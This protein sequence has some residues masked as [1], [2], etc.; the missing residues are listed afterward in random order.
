M[1]A[2]ISSIAFFRPFGALHG[3]DRFRR[4]NRREHQ[5]AR[6]DA[7]IGDHALADQI[8]GGDEVLAH[9]G[10]AAVARCAFGVVNVQ[11]YNRNACVHGFADRLVKGGVILDHDGDTIHLVGDG[12]LDQVVLR[13]RI[14]VAVLDVQIHAEHL[15]GVLGTLLDGHK[16][17]NGRVSVDDERNLERFILPGRLPLEQPAP[18]R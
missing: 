7:V 15:G 11:R 6:D 2:P 14:A 16:E 3:V 10:H 12:G 8:A 18:A 5:I 13:D 9:E 17:F 4:F 1:V